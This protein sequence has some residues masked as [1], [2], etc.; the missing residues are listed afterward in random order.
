MAPPVNRNVCSE[1][2]LCVVPE[3]CKVRGPE[4][5]RVAV[6]L[7]NAAVIVTRV[8]EPLA[9][10]V[11]ELGASASSPGKVRGFSATPVVQLAAKFAGEGPGFQE[12]VLLAARWVPADE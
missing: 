12:P 6:T 9:D 5:E 7:R 1:S 8:P 4:V 10:S 11:G 2:K 3:P